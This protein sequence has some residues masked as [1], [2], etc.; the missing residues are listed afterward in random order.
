MKVPA[1]LLWLALVALV[2]V[3]W[4]PGKPRSGQL[5]GSAG[6]STSAADVGQAR[7][8]RAGTGSLC[9]FTGCCSNPAPVP[10]PVASFLQPYGPAQP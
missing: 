3:S 8:L 1:M 9:E 6:I 5:P 7:H 4:A 2:A 10:T